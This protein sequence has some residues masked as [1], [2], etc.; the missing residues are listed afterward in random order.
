MLCMCNWIASLPSMK[1]ADDNIV[2]QQQKAEPGTLI[3]A[4]KVTHESITKSPIL[5][6]LFRVYQNELQTKQDKKYDSS[7]HLC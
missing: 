4:Q 7:V 3:G 1:L 5:Y 2:S 6:G